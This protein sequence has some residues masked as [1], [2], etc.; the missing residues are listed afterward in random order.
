M[1]STDTVP[2][3]APRIDAAKDRPAPP[4]LAAALR[5]LNDAVERLDRAT[6]AQLDRPRDL[7]GELQAMADDRARLA[8]ELDGAKARGDRL[9]Q[10]NGE[11][12]RRLVGAMETV[13]GVMEAQG[14][15]PSDGD[16]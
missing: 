11:V 15:A 8:E 12:S 14:N 6:K 10:V 9:A 16:D 4:D 1:T 7:G 13:R 3:A 2:L 5:S